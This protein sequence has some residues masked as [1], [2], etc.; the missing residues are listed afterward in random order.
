MKDKQMALA[1][2][3]DYVKQYCPQATKIALFPDYD[4]LV[5]DNC[6]KLVNFPDNFNMGKLQQILEAAEPGTFSI[7]E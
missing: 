3:L 7:V 1:I 6:S 2:A 5:V 4:C